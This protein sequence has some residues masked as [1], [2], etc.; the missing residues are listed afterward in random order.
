MSIEAQYDLWVSL[1]L[2]PSLAKVPLPIRVSQFCWFGAN[3][4]Q[5]SAAGMGESHQSKPMVVQE[6]S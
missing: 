3:S 1:V 2:T 4:I 5:E 6:I